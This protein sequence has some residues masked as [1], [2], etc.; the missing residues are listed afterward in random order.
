MTV[1]VAVAV[2]VA[3]VAVGE[4]MEVG[5]GAGNLLEQQRSFVASTCTLVVFSFSSG[6]GRRRFGECGT[7][8]AIS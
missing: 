3:V 5:E 7:L 1:V 8:P 4:E 2:V 6:W